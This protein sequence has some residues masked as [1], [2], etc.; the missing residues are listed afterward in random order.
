MGRKWLAQNGSTMDFS[1]ADSGFYTAR[2]GLNWFV[3][4]SLLLFWIF[5]PFPWLALFGLNLVQY[6]GI[7][8]HADLYGTSSHW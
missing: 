6:V 3:P 8:F 7:E 5:Y 4:M 2:G 1:V